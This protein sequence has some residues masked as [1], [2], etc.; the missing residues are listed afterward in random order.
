MSRA[1]EIAVRLRPLLILSVFVAAVALLVGGT[2]AVLNAIA[3][4]ACVYLILVVGT[5]V[6][7]GNSGIISFGQVA[8]AAIG[9]YTSALLTMPPDT[10]AMILPDLP[11]FLMNVHTSF[12]GSVLAAGLL[13]GLIALVLALSLMRLSGIAAGIATFAVLVIVYEVLNNWKQVVGAGALSGVP[14]DLDL[15]TAVVFA[16]IVLA[17]A[18]WYQCSRWGLRLRG[19][20]EDEVAARASG[21]NVEFQRGIAFV[22]SAAIMG[23]AGALYAHQQGVL[24]PT[25]FFLSLTFL[26]LAMLVIGGTHSLSGAVVGTF[27]LVAI[28][29]VF[30]RWSTRQGVGPVDIYLPAGTAQIFIAL[31]M[32]L[33]VIRRPEGITGGREIGERLRR[34]SWLRGP[35]AADPQPE[36]AP[37]S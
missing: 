28:Q 26:T 3:I 31:L 6:F 18:F 34:P 16:V 10:K 14:L 19:S 20:R 37:E 13:S 11:E 35:R 7:V 21:I 12:G 2:G 17:I 32:L 27:L 25:A 30:Q 1:S 4:N 5:Y 8:F 29:E 23:V 15:T 36:P 9:A 24:S 33:V 22:L